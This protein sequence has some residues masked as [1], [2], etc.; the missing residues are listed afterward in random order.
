[1][2]GVLRANFRFIDYVNAAWKTANLVG[3]LLYDR[4][5]QRSVKTAQ[6]VSLGELLKF[7]KSLLEPVSYIDREQVTDTVKRPLRFPGWFVCR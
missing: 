6:S 2:R 3:N 7:F 5:L 1:M 4:L